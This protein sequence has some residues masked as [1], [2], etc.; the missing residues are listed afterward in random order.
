MS[1]ATTGNKANK[2]QAA[3]SV[4]PDFKY[5]PIFHEKTTTGEGGV[6]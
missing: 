6:V 1:C 5:N 4:P 3:P 2:F